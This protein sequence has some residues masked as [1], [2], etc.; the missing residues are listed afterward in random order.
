VPPST[1]IAEPAAT[2]DATDRAASPG[3]RR[4][5]S[6]LLIALVALLVLPMV[7]SAAVLVVHTSSRFTPV[8]D[9]SLI[10]MQ[11]RDVGREP[12]VSGLYS[13]QSWSH[14]GP[15]QFYLMA[16]VY[17]LTGS[18]SVGTFVAALVINAVAVVGMVVVAWRR[19]G[20]PLMLI[21]LL[22]ASLLMRTLGADFL[23]D[24]WNCYVTVL[25][26]GFAVFLAWALTCGDT[27]ALPVAVG[28]TSY[29]AQAHVGYVVLALPVLAFGAV[30]LAVRVVGSGDAG[31]RRRLVRATL[32][33]VAVGGVMW[34]PPL[35]DLLVNDPSNLGN[36]ARYFSSDGDAHTVADG[37]NIL[38]PQFAVLPEWLTWH[39]APTWYSGE[40]PAKYDPPL[41][42]LL[43]VFLAAAVVLVRRRHDAVAR[44]VATF[45]VVFALGVLAI[46]RTVGLAFDYRLRW[47]WILGMM[48][49]VVLAWTGWRLVA[50]RWD[51]AGR[52]LGPVA[53]VG[54]V[55]LS[56]VNV[57]S[58]LNAGIPYE[59][60]SE[61]ARAIIPG[62]LEAVDGVEGE[63]LVTDTLLG[64]W[65]ARAVVAELERHGF[66]ARVPP[67]RREL[68]GDHRVVSDDPPAA[69]VHVAVNQEV[70]GLRDH[71]KFR[72][73]AEWEG[74]TDE[75]IDEENRRR[76]EL[77]ADLEA[78]RIGAEAHSV[79][80]FQSQERLHRG[81]DAFGYVAAV[82]LDLDPA[83]AP[84]AV[85]TPA[86]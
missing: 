42:V 21:T 4:P 23:R 13:R 81:G 61:L 53:V 85:P 66:D 84:L 52:V 14:P 7:V 64:S 70:R 55:V 46:S 57:A 20:V 18:S 47:T 39:R 8:A 17:R 74:A 36:I 54:V 11:V 86:G 35:I 1:T 83:D 65:Y 63:V 58:A 6:R 82:F 10:E 75:M 76:A 60:E 12:V 71:P 56:A 27:W 34:A 45:A 38:S 9:I 67:G 51:G 33:A 25:P 5:R 79:G 16:P 28:V 59:D 69:R 15:A 40:P 44:L 32:V 78:G 29:V 2:P 19:G 77:D 50:N 72:L 43:P 30:W 41:P 49:F 37:W 68:F 62:V 24:P 48:A 31:Q 26:F 73:V 22:A 3:E 80:F